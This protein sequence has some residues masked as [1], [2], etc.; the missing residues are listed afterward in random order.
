MFSQLKNIL[1][2]MLK[3]SPTESCS[4]P[5]NKENIL[6]LSYLYILQVMYVKGNEIKLPQNVNTHPY[7]KRMI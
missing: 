7:H 2:S 4:L 5:Y 3:I 6:T 1:R